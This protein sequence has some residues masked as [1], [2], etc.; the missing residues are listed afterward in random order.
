MSKPNKRYNFIGLNREFIPKNE[1]N[2]LLYGNYVNSENNHSEHNTSSVAISKRRKN[3]PKTTHYPK[4]I[5]KYNYKKIS[6]EKK[7]LDTNIF[8]KEAFTEKSTEDNQKHSSESNN[9]LYNIIQNVLLTKKTFKLP[10]K[11][12]FDLSIQPKVFAQYKSKKGEIPR[13]IIIERTKKKYANFDIGEE[14]Y[15]NNITPEDLYNLLQPNDDTIKT[16]KVK[17]SKYADSLKIPL[18]YFDNTDFESRIIEEWLNIDKNPYELPQR[19]ED[20]MPFASIPLPA[21]AFDY[22]EWRDCFVMGYNYETNMWNIKWKETSTWYDEETINSDN[23]DLD[24]YIIDSMLEDRPNSKQTVTTTE[25][26]NNKKS[27][28]ENNLSEDNSKDNEE[29]GLISVS[30][31]IL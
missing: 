20:V 11:S 5:V 7:S 17:Q 13:K 31:Y 8:P 10:S 3:A 18:E 16:D 23:E 15:K 29:H 12:K 30:R 25:N 19:Q 21:V 28:N 9:S 1:K 6:E 14:F 4:V 24:E 2:K 27:N 26:S 22:P